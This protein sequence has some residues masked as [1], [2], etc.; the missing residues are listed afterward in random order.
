MSK[1]ETKSKP[2]TTKDIEM[3][4]SCFRVGE[5]PF[6]HGNCMVGVQRSHNVRNCTEQPQNIV[7]QTINYRMSVIKVEINVCVL[8][9]AH[10]ISQRWNTSHDIAWQVHNKQWKFTDI[11]LWKANNHNS[12]NFAAQIYQFCESFVTRINFTMVC[13]S[14]LT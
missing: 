4:L 12:N 8:M 11:I 14:L 5:W 3:I 13:K 10:Y 6:H 9:L 7:T 1:L 2:N